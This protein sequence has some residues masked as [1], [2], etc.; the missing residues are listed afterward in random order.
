MLGAL[1]ATAKLWLVLLDTAML[2]GR[3]QD[4]HILFKIKLK[5]AMKSCTLVAFFCQTG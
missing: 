3:K 2:P 4:L 1:E 5:I